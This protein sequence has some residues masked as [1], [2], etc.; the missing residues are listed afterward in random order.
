MQPIEDD[1]NKENINPQ[2]M[3]TTAYARGMSRM[4]TIP[5][6][7][8]DRSI[9][10]L[11]QENER[12][13]LRWRITQLV[14]FMVDEPFP[15]PAVVTDVQSYYGVD[16]D[17]QDLEDWLTILA[18]ANWYCDPMTYDEYLVLRTARLTM[19]RTMISEI[20]GISYSFP[21]LWYTFDNMGELIDA[22]TTWPQPFVGQ[23]AIVNDFFNNPQWLPINL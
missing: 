17:R 13:R 3:S 18:T 8:R 23:M 7:V 21:A 12:R 11:Q 16:Y 20:P 10:L 9:L 19:M 22:T 1:T 15:G 14:R 5:G 6:L 2:P 4:L